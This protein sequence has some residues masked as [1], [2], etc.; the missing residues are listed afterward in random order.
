MTNTLSKEKRPS[1]LKYTITITKTAQRQLDKL[2]EQVSAQLI[3][4]ILSLSENPRPI[5]YKKLKG[6]SGYRVRKLQSYL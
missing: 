6:R 5:G 1:V 4:L 3:D 2:P